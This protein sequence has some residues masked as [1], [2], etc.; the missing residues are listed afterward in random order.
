LKVFGDDAF[1]K[2]SSRCKNGV[3]VVNHLMEQNSVLFLPV[4]HALNIQFLHGC[5]MKKPSEP[6]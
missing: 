3:A 1:G 6:Q 5:S 2:M 4:L